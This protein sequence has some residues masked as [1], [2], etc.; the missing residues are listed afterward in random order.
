MCFYCKFLLLCS[1]FYV[2]RCNPHPPRVAWVVEAHAL[3]LTLEGRLFPH[4]PNERGNTD[5][6][7]PLPPPPPLPLGSS[8]NNISKSGNFKLLGWLATFFY[9]GIQAQS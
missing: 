3:C 4:A 9:G 5:D 2:Y 8:K 6:F 1:Y 7:V